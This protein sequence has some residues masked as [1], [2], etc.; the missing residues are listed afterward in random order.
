MEVL[1]AVV[2]LMDQVLD[3][4]FLVRVTMVVLAHGE[5][6]MVTGSVEAGAVE[7]GK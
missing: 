4:L 1:G 6:K 2:V 7:L 3:L 5:G